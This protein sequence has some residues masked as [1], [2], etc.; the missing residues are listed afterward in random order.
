MWFSRLTVNA[1]CDLSVGRS[2]VPSCFRGWLLT[3]WSKKIEFITE[4]TADLWSRST[5]NLPLPW[6]HFLVPVVSSS[7]REGRVC[8]QPVVM[9]CECHRGAVLYLR[10]RGRPLPL[11]AWHLGSWGAWW[12]SKRNLKFNTHTKSYSEHTTLQPILMLD[13]LN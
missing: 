5:S 9:C 4:E 8:P 1:P 7:L 12:K 13:G 2:R 11:M 6:L 3:L 10:R